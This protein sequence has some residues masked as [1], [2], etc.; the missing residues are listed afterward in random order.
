MFRD[1]NFSELLSVKYG[2]GAW[3]RQEVAFGDNLDEDTT[4]ALGL[5]E[6][7]IMERKLT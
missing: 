3:L 5:W 2:L 1:K 7:R 4:E 6:K